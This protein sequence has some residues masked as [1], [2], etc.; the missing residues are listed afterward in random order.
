M[1][2]WSADYLLYN[3]Y[4]RAPLPMHALQ[5]GRFEVGH[6]ADDIKEVIWQ[7]RGSTF[8]I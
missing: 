7:G 8:M 6:T 4:L 3:R 2:R 5:G 1:V